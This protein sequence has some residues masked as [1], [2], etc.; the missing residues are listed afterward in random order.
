MQK[1]MIESQALL[2]VGDKFSLYFEAEEPQYEIVEKTGEK[3]F[4]VKRL[5]SGIIDEK[6]IIPHPSGDFPVWVWK[7][8][9]LK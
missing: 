6:Q 5:P 4:S 2:K 8:Q 9:K 7:E 1:Q 3:E